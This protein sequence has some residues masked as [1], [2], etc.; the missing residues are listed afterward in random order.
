MSQTEQS[1][2]ISV[3]DLGEG[4]Q[5]V[6]ITGLLL[7]PGDAVARDQ[8]IYAVETDKAA[9][10]MESPCQGVLQEWLVAVGERVAVGTPVAALRVERVDE[11]RAPAKADAS[12]HEAQVPVRP[13]TATASSPGRSVQI[14]PRV[15]AE[16]RAAGL[17][18]EQIA[19]IPATGERLSVEDL[20][21]FVSA[22]KASLDENSPG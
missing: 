13:A 21:R 20:Q 11:Q 22:R 6:R 16:G 15:R 7:Q 3:P 19:A 10:D 2:V 17:T 18:D 12:S 8:A 4:L 5:E 9:F 14:P 1:Y